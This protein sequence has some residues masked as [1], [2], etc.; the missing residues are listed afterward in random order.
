MKTITGKVSHIKTV[1]SPIE[2]DNH[3]IFSTIF[4]LD[5]RCIEIKT[6]DEIGVNNGDMMV[7]AGM[8]SR[9]AIFRAYSY[10]KI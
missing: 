2:I 4:L 5:N 1:E 9:N 6:L 10:R 3:K 7:V 8:E